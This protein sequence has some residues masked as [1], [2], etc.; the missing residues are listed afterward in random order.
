MVWDLS[1][2]AQIMIPIKEAKNYGAVGQI[3]K[4]RGVHYSVLLE[5]THRGKKETVSRLLGVWW[6]DAA[7]RG[8]VL[9]LPVVNI[10][11]VTKPVST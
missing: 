2:G 7:I 4:K 6:V 9:C 11:A 10:N 3:S 8:S 1:I 5:E